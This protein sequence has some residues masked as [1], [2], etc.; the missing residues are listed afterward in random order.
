LTLLRRIRHLNIPGIPGIP[1]II[2]NLY[3]DLDFDAGVFECGHGRGVW[4]GWGGGCV[5]RPKLYYCIFI[6]I[7]R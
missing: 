4:G 7:S 3:F 6:N 5:N 1:G 2:P